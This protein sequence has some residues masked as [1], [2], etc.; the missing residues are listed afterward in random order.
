MVIV[1][2][3]VTALQNL[4]LLFAVLFV[5]FLIDYLLKTLQFASDLA[6]SI[7]HGYYF[8]LYYFFNK[9]FEKCVK[10]FIKNINY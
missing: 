5:T 7:K 8:A 9:K 2:S 10:D 1:I 3:F 6:L 4:T